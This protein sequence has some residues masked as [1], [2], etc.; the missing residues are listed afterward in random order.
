MKTLP[1]LVAS[2]LV[3]SA[4]GCG[5]RSPLDVSD[6]GGAGAGAAGMG[7]SPPS[8]N[9]A[10]GTVQ[11]CGGSVEG[12][13]KVAKTCI[14]NGGVV[15]DAFDGCPTSTFTVTKISA[16]G[17]VTFAPDGTYQESGTLALD[18]KLTI[19]DSC[20]AGGCAFL[21]SGLRQ[22]SDPSIMSTVSC[23]TSG[24]TC[25]CQLS[26]TRGAETGTYDASGTTLTTS[27]NGG[28][29]TSMDPYCVSGDEL[30]DI[31]LDMSMSVGSLGM[32]KIVG[33][34]VY[35]RQ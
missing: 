15:G 25:V 3:A 19:P 4:L 7:G 20:V 17:T 14:V 6:T 13:W 27:A 18:L 33:D 28:G 12:T 10:C 21:E 11:P 30:H 23:A 31:A 34:I 5:G 1:R 29:T 32:A 22:S 26:E 35:T 16:T 8:A 9:V 24:G 2:V